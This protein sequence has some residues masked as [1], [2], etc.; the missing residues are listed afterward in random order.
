[1]RLITRQFPV[2]KRLNSLVKGLCL[3]V[4]CSLTFAPTYVKSQITPDG[5]VNTET[6]QEGN[7]VDITGG[8]REGNN[9]FH[10]FEEFSI[11]TG[12]EA[13]FLNDTDIENI[14]T[15]VTGGAASNIDGVLRAQGSANLFLINPSGIVFGENARLDLGGSFVGTTANNVEFADGNSFS[16]D[17]STT[18]PVLTVS[19]PVGLGFMGNQPGPIVVN[20]DGNKIQ[21]SF[22]S[23]PTT[24]NDSVIGLSVQPGKTLALVGSDVNVEG[25]TIR[26]EGGQIELGSVGSGLVS[27]KSIDRGWTLGYEGIS[28]F[29]DIRLSKQA[30]IDNSGTGR[31]TIEVSGANVN[32]L[33]GSLI[34][35]QNSGDI[36]SESLNVNATESIFLRGVSPDGN[37]SSAIRSE[38]IGQGKAADITITAKDLVLQNGGRIGATAYEEGKSGDVKVNA[39]DSVQ[40]LENTL[41]NPDR[42]SFLSSGISSTTYGTGNAGN[43]QL[44]T[45]ELK[46]TSGAGISS[47]TLKTGAGGDV[48]INAE[49]IE[50]TGVEP[51]RKAFSAI[52]ASS[53]SPNSGEA[54]N[55]TV[56]TSTLRLTDGGA[57]SSSSFGA[58]SAGSLNVN[59]SKDIEVSGISG[60]FPSII[61]SSVEP[62]NSKSAQDRLGLP[63]IPSG[64]S[65][66][67]T[68]NT[69]SLNVNSGGE[70]SVKNEG[71]GEA[72]T[73]R[74]NADSINLNNSGNIL[75]TTASGNGGNIDIKTNQLSLDE[76][77]K[78]SAT[79]ANNGNG[80]N[81]NIK[82]IFL[83]AKKNSDI[84]ANANFGTGG[85]ITIDTKILMRSPDSDI[86]AS[87]QKGING[88]VN[89]VNNTEED[90][91]KYLILN[92]PLFI[93]TKKLIANSCLDRYRKRLEF[94]NKRG[95][96]MPVN[97][98]SGIDIDET[99]PIPTVQENTEMI[100]TSE[101]QEAIVY[102]S[103]NES[104]WQP[105]E[106]VIE[107]NAIVQTADGRILGV[108]K[109]QP[110]DINSLVC[111]E[112]N[113]DRNQVV[114]TH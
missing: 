63:S 35:A 86:T 76:E 31:A 1:M 40:L 83:S 53:A 64:N 4:I 77:S 98:D 110:E 99:A 48:T 87:S 16:A 85:N 41:V 61:R 80:G 21:P 27:L 33:D 2:R 84:T 93:D 43:L 79:A 106:P 30:V 12:E 65:G 29:K 13:T 18:N 28:N 49:N 44:S 102:P 58:G 67:V 9:L 101:E 38:T 113:G 97:P 6:Q 10:S 54:G 91:R 74:I 111:H 39:F 112:A 73:L 114:F 78:L 34:L 75:A 25:G 82:T 24:V 105:G 17:D 60:N 11:P 96:V 23:T 7:N 51:I 19:V 90:L 42:K 20:G 104:P 26:T 52:A 8:S 59:A 32:L 81:I 50:V 69:P 47:T 92:V 108:R 55:L 70:V 15:R 71:T 89:F 5:T 56:N 94:A 37:V 22:S 103:E 46:V 109:L 3:G 88:T 72:G 107:A 36:P 66:E 95:G 14:F 62:T 68:I 57:V 45:Q 100:V